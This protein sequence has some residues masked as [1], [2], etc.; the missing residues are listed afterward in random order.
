MPV[1]FDNRAARSLVGHLSGAI[2]GSSIARGTSFLKD[3]MGEDIFA[4]GITIVDDPHRIRGLRSA[5]FDDEGLPTQRRNIID[6]GKLTTWFL[7]SEERR[8]GKEGR[9]RGSPVS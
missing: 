4:P 7:G 5:A 3:K 2:N 8:V 1:V 9:T 6:Q